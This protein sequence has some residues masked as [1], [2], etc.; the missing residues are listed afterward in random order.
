[1]KAEFENYHETSKN[2]DNTR[3]PVGTEILLGCF[4]SSPRPLQGQTILDAGCGTGNY[5]RA[6]NGKVGM[7]VGL[8]FNEGMLAQA[9][10]KFQNNPNIRLYLGSLLDL[11]YA[12]DSF[13][14][15]VCNQ[16]LH[17]LNT[18]NVGQE[19]FSPV[20]RMLA[21]AYR[22]LRPQGAL[23]VN[24]S[25]H[26]QLFDGFWWAD[27]I[28]AAMDRIAKRFPSLELLAS[29]LEESGFN[30]R[31]NIVPL[32][33]VLQGKNYLD[34]EGPLKK[35]YQNGDSTWSLATNEELEHALG[36]VRT[37][38]EDGSMARYLE[39]RETLRRN[40]GQTTCVFARKDEQGLEG[41]ETPIKGRDKKKNTSP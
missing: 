29:M 30:F 34:P 37:M 23:V 31:G 32:N 25:S 40:I 6:L 4:A 20:R 24:T 41:L 11:P 39:A 17:H 10:E 36:R 16:V 35:N 33:S 22:V 2:Y 8:E 15:I 1:M 13:D 27:L 26:Q 9:R 18:G 14:G 21:E 28:P 3:V 12:A 19:N 7:L 38:N 5:I